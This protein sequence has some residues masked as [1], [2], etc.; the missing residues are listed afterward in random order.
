MIGRHFAATR[1]GAAKGSDRS[2]TAY[3]ETRPRAAIWRIRAQHI[4]RALAKTRQGTMRTES[5]QS[6]FRRNIPGAKIQ[7]FETDHF[8]LETQALIH[9][10]RA[11][12]PR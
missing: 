7:F 5:V 1:R 11:H 6:R 12:T 4:S 10:L 8:A 3:C 9:A 2:F